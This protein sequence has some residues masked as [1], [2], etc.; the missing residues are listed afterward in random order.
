MVVLRAPCPHF[1]QSC[2]GGYGHYRI[3]AQYFVVSSIDNTERI[4]KATT[5]FLAV[6]LTDVH[7][8]HIY[9]KTC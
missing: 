3:F 4:I 8:K 2:E 7:V 9:A 6:L 5:K 1:I